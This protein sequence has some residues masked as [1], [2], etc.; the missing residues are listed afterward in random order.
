MIQIRQLHKSYGSKSVLTDVNVDLHPGTVYGL[1]GNNGTGKSTLL[2]ILL[3][4]I[5]ANQGM[6]EIFGMRYPNDTLNIRAIMGVLP[7]KRTYPCRT[8]S[9]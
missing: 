1:L 3:D 6:V 4:L 8:H 5:P 7:E 2:N 9:L